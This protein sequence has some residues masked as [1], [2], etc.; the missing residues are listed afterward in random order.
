MNNDEIR[1]EAALLFPGGVNSPVRSFR[2]V[3]GKPVPIVRGAGA[4]A[5]DADG[6][7]YVDY[8]AAFGPLILPHAHPEVV[9][10]IATAAAEGTAF[11]ASRGR[12]G[13]NSRLS[14]QRELRSLTPARRNQAG[15][16]Q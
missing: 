3:G 16:D 6:G 10:A 12:R 5:F 13:S 15:I 14:G 7:R 11:G 1:R 9:R 2:S 4:H 8:I